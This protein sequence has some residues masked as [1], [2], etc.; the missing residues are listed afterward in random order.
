MTITEYRTHYH[1][2]IFFLC[3]NFF[4]KKRPRKESN[5]NILAFSK[6]TEEPKPMEDPIIQRIAKKH[7]KTP[8]QVHE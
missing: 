1:K 5:T 8:A 7:G 2:K 4:V 6:E 3:K